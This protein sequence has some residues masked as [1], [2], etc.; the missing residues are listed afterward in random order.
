MAAVEITKT[1][2][3]WAARLTAAA[4]DK[5][6]REVRARA[7]VSA[8]LRKKNSHGNS[9]DGKSLSG[10]GGSRHG[11]VSSFAASAASVALAVEVAEI[12]ASGVAGPSTTTNEQ[13]RRR[14]RRRCACMN[15]MRAW[16]LLLTTDVVDCRFGCVCATFRE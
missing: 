15:A 4:A 5:A 6:Q 8:A 12:V 14:T 2:E 7:A 3:K 16:L 9:A 11:P 1:E 13:P 10:S